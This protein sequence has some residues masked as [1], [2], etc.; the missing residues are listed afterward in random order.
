M[1][2]GSPISEQYEEGDPEGMGTPQYVDYSRKKYS[3]HYDRDDDEY[4][5]IDQVER[6]FDENLNIASKHKKCNYF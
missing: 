3:D 1:A 5:E 4:Q 2:D 6:D